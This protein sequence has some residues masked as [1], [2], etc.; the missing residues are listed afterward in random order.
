MAKLDSARI[1]A[2]RRKH[3]GGLLVNIHGVGGVH[4]H[5]ERHLVLRDAGNGFGIAELGIGLP[6]DFVDRI[7]HAA[8]QR[9][10][11]VRRIFQVEHRLAV[12]TAL[13]ALIHAGQKS[14]SPQLFA[15]VRLVAARDQHDETGK[16]LVLRAQ[17]IDHPGTHGRIAEASI[18]SLYQ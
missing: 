2:V 3:G 15:A 5:A 4:L 11:Y 17:P 9:P 13:H 7:Q 1:R 6:V 16:V 14:G 8:A 10:A 12:G 18:A